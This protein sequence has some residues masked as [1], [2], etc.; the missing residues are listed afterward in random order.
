MTVY[1]YFQEL[2]HGGKEVSNTVIPIFY[3]YLYRYEMQHLLEL[4]G[5]EVE[6]LYGDF[7]RNPLHHGTEQVWVARKT[8]SA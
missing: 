7:R 2:D 6:A 1:Q 8:A 3:R 5:F 4:C